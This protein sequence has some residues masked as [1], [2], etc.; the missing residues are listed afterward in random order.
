MEHGPTK[1]KL[2]GTSDHLCSVYSGSYFVANR[3]RTIHDPACP[4]CFYCV[5]GSVRFCRRHSDMVAFRKPLRPV[6]RDIISE[7]KY[8][9]KIR[10][11]YP[12]M[13][14]EALDNINRLLEELHRGTNS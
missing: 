12:Q 13:K 8:W 9:R 3:L 2:G 7:L 5:S 10:L 4:P 1:S 14:Q 6:E 11:D